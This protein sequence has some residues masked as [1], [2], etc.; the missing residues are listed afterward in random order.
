MS[1][2]TKPSSCYMREARHVSE[3]TEKVQD[4]FDTMMARLQ[5][6]KQKTI[7]SGTGLRDEDY[8]ADETDQDYF[9]QRCEAAVKNPEMVGPSEV[10]YTPSQLRRQ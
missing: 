10:K 9:L 7:K 4:R 2:N 1:S 3:W 6:H 5:C 8:L